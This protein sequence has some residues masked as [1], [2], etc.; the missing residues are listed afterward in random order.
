M[1]KDKKLEIEKQIINL[2]AG[3]PLNETRFILKNVNEYIDNR[4]I[5]PKVEESPNT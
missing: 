3:M 2:L 1:E 5:V 4:S